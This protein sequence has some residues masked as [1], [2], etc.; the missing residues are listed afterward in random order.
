MASSV[1]LGR[2]YCG[3]KY[4]I[5]SGIGYLRVNLPLPL[6]ATS[7]DFARDRRAVKADAVS[8]LVAQALGIHNLLLSERRLNCSQ[9]AS[10]VEEREKLRHHSIARDSFRH[11]DTNVLASSRSGRVKSISRSNGRFQRYWLRTRGRICL[12][13]L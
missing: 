13:R 5:H 8:E 1:N 9:T 3:A 2:F 11:H 6:V 12:K 10:N 4:L 7:F